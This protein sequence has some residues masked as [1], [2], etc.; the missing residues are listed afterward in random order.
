MIPKILVVDDND[1]IRL[2]L[3]LT[4]KTEGYDVETAADG[5]EAFEKFQL[6]EPDVLVT[7]LIMPE[8]DGRE[9]CRRVRR[10]SEV[11]ILIITGDLGEHSDADTVRHLGANGY[12]TKPFDLDDFVAQVKNLLTNW[13]EAQSRPQR[14]DDDVE[15]LS[16]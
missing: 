16:S 12:L 10:M 13:R 5:I 4:L 2:L 3:S 11:P 14:L 15:S 6:S 7:D 1:S 8:M 9:L